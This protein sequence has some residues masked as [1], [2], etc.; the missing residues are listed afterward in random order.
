MYQK[1]SFFLIVPLLGLNYR[2]AP[3]LVLS[4]NTQFLFWGSQTIP[5][6]AHGGKKVDVLDRS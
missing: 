1:K 2:P 6:Q 3:Y 4:L 5:A